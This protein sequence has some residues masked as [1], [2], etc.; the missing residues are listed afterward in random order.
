[1]DAVAGHSLFPFKMRWDDCPSCPNGS[2]TTAPVIIH[3]LGNLV[4]AL[5][6][7]CTGVVVPQRQLV[8]AG[9]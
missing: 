2:Y 7:Q 4:L 1:M 8:G 9:Y 6:L 5:Q 3:Y